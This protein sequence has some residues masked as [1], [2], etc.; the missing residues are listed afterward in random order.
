MAASACGLPS[1]FVLTVIVWIMQILSCGRFQFRLNQPQSIPI[2]MGILNVTPD[3][4]SDGG[5]Y[6][7]LDQALNHAEK[8]IR[9]GVD[10]IDIGGESTRPGATP[11][12]LQEELDRVMPAIFALRDCGKALSID[13]R[14]PEVMREAVIAGVDMVND[15]GGFGLLAAREAV[16]QSEVGLCVMHMQ[17]TP[18]D[19]QLQP[20]YKDVNREIID[21]LREKIALL[22]THGVA[23]ERI[24]VDPGF[25]FGKTLAHN[26]E[27]FEQL[28][29]Y[30]SELGA[31]VL[32]GVSR[33]SMIGVLTGK[34]IEQR[35]AG[36]VAA[37]LFAAKQGAHLIRVHDVAETVDA[38]KVWQAFRKL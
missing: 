4:F 32:V 24:C 37:A 29:S 10:I 20:Q 13:T 31:A 1:F 12:S 7:H 11:L 22:A 6:Q 25:G 3:S 18:S 21:F 16:A 34:P 19:M 38:L 17:N 35:M 23:R 26:I 33:K 5:R 36:S 27:I 15:V 30:S 14:K 28:S 8:M 9:D 2:V